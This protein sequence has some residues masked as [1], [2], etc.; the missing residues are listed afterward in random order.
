MPCI[1]DCYTNVIQTNAYDNIWIRKDDQLVHF[2]PKAL[3]ME[4]KGVKEIN[5]ILYSERRIHRS[6]MKEFFQKQAS[7]H[8]LV[9]IDLKIH[10]VMPWSEGIK[11]QQY[12]N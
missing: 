7:D 11:L 3:G 8:N 12:K 1:R 2:N 9:F 6:D 4:Q 10:K 5:T